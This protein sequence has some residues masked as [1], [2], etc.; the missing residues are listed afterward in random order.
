M[1]TK[2]NDPNGILEK[3]AFSCKEYHSIVQEMADEGYILDPEIIE[4]C[5]A[6]GIKFKNKGL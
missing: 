2:S 3:F 5:K 1:K 4:I 6:N